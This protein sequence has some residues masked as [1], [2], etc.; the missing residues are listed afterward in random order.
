MGFIDEDTAMAGIATAVYERAG[1]SG[2]DLE[3]ALWRL[4]ERRRELRGGALAV[5]VV[6]EDLTWEAALT[7]CLACGYPPSGGADIC[8]DGCAKAKADYGI[9]A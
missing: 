2:E 6:V 5:D 3:D 9:A 4:D 8:E 1:L 7:T